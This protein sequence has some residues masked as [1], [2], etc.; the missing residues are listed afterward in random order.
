MKNCWCCGALCHQGL[1]SSD[2]WEEEPKT[3]LRVFW[4][5]FLNPK[6]QYCTPKQIQSFMHCTVCVSRLLFF[7][8]VML[9]YLHRCSVC[10]PALK[11]LDEVQQSYI[12]S[13]SLEDCCDPGKIH[14]SWR[15]PGRV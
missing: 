13:G 6:L 1:R 3:Q 11:I 8:L 5:C 15:S 12:S 7:S 10:G 14:I 4:V 2:L 9:E